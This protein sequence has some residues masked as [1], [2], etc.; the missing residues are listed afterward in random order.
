MNVAVVFNKHPHLPPPQLKAIGGEIMRLFDGATF[1]VCRH[2]G[3]AY[4]PGAV[5]LEI[6]QSLEHKAKIAQIAEALLA[7]NP[8]YLVSV[9]GDGLSSYL[10]LHISRRTVKPIM[11]AIAAGTA[12]VGPIVSF[13]GEHLA[14]LT[15]ASLQEVAI[16]AIAVSDENGFL[17]LGFNDV[18]LADT[19]LGT[20]G[21][22]C[23]NLSVEE[24]LLRGRRVATTVGDRITTDGFSVLVDGEPCAFNRSVPIAQIVISPLQFDRL[25]GRAIFGALC[26]GRDAT[27]LAAVGLI[28]GNVVN[29]D[30]RS[31][32]SDDFTAI[33]HLLFTAGETVTF[34]GLG[35]DAHI[36]IDGNPYIRRGAVSCTV[37]TGAIHA[38]KPKGGEIA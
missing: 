7:V 28:S 8:R 32:E 37:M 16:D 3:D 22:V 9:G 33:Q 27:G 29:S 36:V 4:L 31:W 5:V 35:P 34:D 25:Y 11:L 20:E 15:H 14:H 10:A 12:N 1:F 6:D 24:L 30:P 26:H 38:L 17:G 19:F 13:K 2:H 23:R 21:G 18:I